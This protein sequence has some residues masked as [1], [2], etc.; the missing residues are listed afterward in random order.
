LY[1]GPDG[2]KCAI[3]GI[4][5]DEVYDK[6]NARK[7]DNNFSGTLEGCRIDIFPDELLAD[8]ELNP[9]DKGFYKGLQSIHDVN[10]VWEWKREL[11][12]VGETFNLNLEIPKSFPDFPRPEAGENVEAEI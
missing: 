2:L 3:G 7:I 11:I 5:S 4:M 9:E 12:H 10:E 1:R 6:W 8:M